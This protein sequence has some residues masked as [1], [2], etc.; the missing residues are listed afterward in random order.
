MTGAL[1][2]KDEMEGESEDDANKQK[3]LESVPEKKE[4]FIIDAF[5]NKFALNRLQQ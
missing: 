5:R 3:F 4:N 1:T 2:I